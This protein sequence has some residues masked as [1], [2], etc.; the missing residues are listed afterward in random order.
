MNIIDYDG[1]YFL[2]CEDDDAFEFSFFEFDGKLANA[3]KN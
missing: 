2:P 1:F 3:K